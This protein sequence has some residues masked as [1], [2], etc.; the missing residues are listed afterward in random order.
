MNH[1]F[2]ANDRNP[3][4]YSIFTAIDIKIIFHVIVF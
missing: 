4:D 2:T 3:L 1:N